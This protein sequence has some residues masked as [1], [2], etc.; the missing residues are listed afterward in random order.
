[1][2]SRCLGDAA[3]SEDRRYRYV[4]WRR[5]DDR[6]PLT[7]FVLLNPST[8]DETTD[9]PTI[10][11]CIAFARSWGDGG[12]YVTNLF[13]LRATDPGRLRRAKD[14]IGARNDDWI[15]AIAERCGRIVVGWGEHGRYRD[16]G[17]DVL[18]RLLPRDRTFRFGLTRASRQPMHPL[19]LR[20]GRT[21]EA[22]W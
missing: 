8:A 18:E 1:M 15:R 12:V 20:R 11:R 17:A 13:A 2:G 9:D 4:L 16:R 7:C 5:W 10:R 19:Y 3:F 21:L 6:R 22:A 14:P